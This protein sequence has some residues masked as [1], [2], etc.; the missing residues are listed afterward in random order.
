MSLSRLTQPNNFGLTAKSLSLDGTLNVGGDTT[1]KGVDCNSL[2]INAVLDS[3]DAVV[4]NPG[5]VFQNEGDPFISVVDN[6]RIGANNAGAGLTLDFSNTSQNCNMVLKGNI[7]ADNVPALRGAGTWSGGAD[8][9][10]VSATG[11]VAGDHVF[12]SITTPAT[13]AVEYSH[14]VAGTDQFTVHLSGANTS[15]DLAFVWHSLPAL[16]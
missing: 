14:V 13:E 2:Q 3:S 12:V 5:L 9:L 15:N 4:S 1:F 16:A 8:S 6:L 11:M 10:V 7:T